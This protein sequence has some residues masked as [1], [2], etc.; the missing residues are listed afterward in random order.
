MNFSPIFMSIF[1]FLAKVSINVINID[2]FSTL[3]WVDS[4]LR[5]DESR[6]SGPVAAQTS[7]KIQ[8]NS[9]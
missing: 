1:C 8:Q 2:K 6:R 7:Q 3:V 9:P 5:D 4:T